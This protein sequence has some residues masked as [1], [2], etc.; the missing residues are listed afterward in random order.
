MATALAK[1]AI[2]NAMNITEKLLSYT[3]VWEKLKNEKS[4]IVLYG[5]G[6]GADTVLDIFESLNIKASAICA[7]DGFVR[8]RIFR[9]FE[10]ISISDAKERFENPLFCLS[11]ASSINDVMEN[12]KSL[13]PLVPV[14]PVFGKDYIDRDFIVGNREKIDSAY[15]LLSDDKSKEVFENILTFE[16]TGELSYLLKTESTREEALCKL[17][18]LTDKEHYADLG[19]YRGDTVEELVNLC[20]SFKKAYAFEPDKKTFL[21]LKENTKD[22]E[23]LTLFPYA[24]WSENTTLNFSGGGGRQSALSN[25]GYEVEA[26]ALDNILGDKKI[27]YIKADVEGAEKE[28]LEGMSRILKEQKPKL[29]ISAYHR[30]ADIFELILQI[31]SINPDY[32]ISL[33]HHPYIPAWDTNLYCM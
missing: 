11:F 13:N 12:I 28:A 4:P 6:N 22:F 23:N 1:P 10:V 25:E 20:G 19:A 29:C 15:N 26:V 33:R 24:L 27:T 30:S 5:T 18:K 16:F 31:H 14:V 7:S 17:L 21:K 9:G 32:T 2:L 3:S 8:K